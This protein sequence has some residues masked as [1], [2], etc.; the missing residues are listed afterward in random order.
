MRAALMDVLYM[1]VGSALAAA[2]IWV[3]YAIK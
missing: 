3:V 2:L 1:F